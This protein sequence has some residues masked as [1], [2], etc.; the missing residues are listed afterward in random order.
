[1]LSHSPDILLMCRDAICSD[2]D[3]GEACLM[4]G[5]KDYSSFYRA[6]K[7]EFGLCPKEYQQIFGRNHIKS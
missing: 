7:K 1:V 3:I 4:Y 5:F 6:F 2:T